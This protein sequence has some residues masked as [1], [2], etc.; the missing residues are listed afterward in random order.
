MSAQAA[1]SSEGSGV[2]LPSPA[3]LGLA[4]LFAAAGGPLQAALS[5]ATPPG[6]QHA[7]VA[8][9]TCRLW[10]LD[11]SQ[12]YAILRQQQP[13]LLAHLARRLLGGLCPGSNAVAAAGETP[14]KQLSCAAEQ[15]QRQVGGAAEARG[16]LEQLA[17]ELDAEALAAAA[18]DAHSK[19]GSKDSMAATAL[20]PLTASSQAS[21]WEEGQPGE[22]EESGSLEAV[23]EPAQVAAARVGFVWGD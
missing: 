5:S 11:C 13:A 4:E 17:A 22:E 15:E 23:A 9:T 18:L 3:V 12:L 14:G 21:G 20:K 1:S 19:A 6:W 16:L 2:Q 10:R 8:L 7:A